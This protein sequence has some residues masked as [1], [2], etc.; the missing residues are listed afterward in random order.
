MTIYDDMA[1]AL[2][3]EMSNV[4]S[5]GTLIYV[6]P[7]TATGPEWDPQ[8]GVPTEYPC[9]G[10]AKGV[11]QKYL[12]AGYITSS[13]I[14]CTITPFGTEP[15]TE[16]KLSI[17]GTLREIIKV[18]RIPAAGTLIAWRVFCKG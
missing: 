2:A 10:V 7:G 14:Q 13:D 16:G 4:F 15:N 3:S 5:Q 9:E 17:D 6:E 11:Q 18:G 1:G 8:P 12:E